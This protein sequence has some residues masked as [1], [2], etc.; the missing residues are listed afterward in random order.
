MMTMPVDNII[1]IAD[2][3]N[4][5]VHPAPDSDSACGFADSMDLIA[6]SPD[7]AL[8]FAVLTRERSGACI[9]AFEAEYG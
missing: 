9:K 1:L 7:A 2:G 8:A 5:V 3:G 6:L 4:V